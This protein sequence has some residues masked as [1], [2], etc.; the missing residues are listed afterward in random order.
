MMLLVATM[1]AIDFSVPL[2]RFE[3]GIAAKEWTAAPF[4]LEGHAP[5]FFAYQ[6]NFVQF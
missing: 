4:A 2:V 1:A 6:R 3:Y 5:V